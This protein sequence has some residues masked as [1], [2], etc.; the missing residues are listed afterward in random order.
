[1]LRVKQIFVFMA[2]LS[3][4][5]SAFSQE[6]LLSMRIIYEV[7]IMQARVVSSQLRDSVVYDYLVDKRFWWQTIDFVNA[8]AKDKK[9]FL[10]NDRGD[11]LNYD[12]VMCNL[13][14]AFGKAFGRIC[15]KEDLQ[16]LIEEE[17]RAIKFEEQWFYNPESMLI[18]KKVLAFC[19]VIRKDTVALVGEELQAKEAFR[20]EMG[21]IKPKGDVMLRDTLVIARNIE[22]SMPIY[23]PQAYHWWDSHLEAEYSIPFLERLI[24]RAETGELKAYENPSASEELLRTEV[25]KRRQFDILERLITSDTE[26]GVSERDTIIKSS[27]NSENIDHFRFGEEWCFDKVNLNFIKRTNYFAPMVSI[28]GKQGDFRGLYPLYYIRRR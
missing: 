28:F 13:S 2:A 23:N 9:L 4:W 11:S 15:T 14:A 20:F 3:I 10:L 21:W 6:K 5:L 1:M 22:F 19:P 8:A 27:Y 16:R 12:T 25:L 26:G 17:V 24:A 7:P 18:G